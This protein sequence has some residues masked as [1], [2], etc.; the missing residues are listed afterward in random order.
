MSSILSSVI[1]I[2]ATPIGNLS[3]I[4]ARA[5]ATLQAVDL[6]AAEDTRHS[7]QLLSHLGINN[8]LLPLHDHNERE[9]TASLLKQVQQGVSIAII[10]DAGTPLISDPGYHFVREAHKLGIK[11]IPI[12][13]PSAVICALSA[14]GLPTDH[15]SFE[16]FLPSKEKAKQDILKQ[17]VNDTHTL[18]FYEAPHRVLATIATMREIFGSEREVAM[19][20]ELTKQFETIFHGTMQQLLDF[21]TSDANQQR[22]EIVLLV[23]GAVK[24]VD[25]F[26]LNP[27]AKKILDIL[28]A[29]LPVSQAV[30]LAAK[31]TGVQKKILYAA[32][33]SGL[34]I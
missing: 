5:I 2:V 8:T 18:V 28:L 23:A 26:A 12:P 17:L 33:I 16:G 29:E 30:G 11:V 10:S 34:A 20:R 14:C 31:I 6:I 24:N 25:K 21:V 7:K 27:E 15:F 1:Y 3:D 13:G 32:A 4:S 22:G 9:Q 19:A